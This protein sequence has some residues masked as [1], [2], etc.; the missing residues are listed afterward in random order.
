MNSAN[1]ESLNNRFTVIKRFYLEESNKY[2]H[3]KNKL[4]SDRNHQNKG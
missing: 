2:L 3:F 1:S 4:L